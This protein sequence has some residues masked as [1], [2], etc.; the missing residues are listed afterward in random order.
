MNVEN[1]DIKRL[2]KLN[3]LR[4]IDKQKI[5]CESIKVVKKLIQYNPDEIFELHTNEEIY[6]IFKNT[7]PHHCKVYIYTNENLAK[8]KGFKFHQKVIAIAKK[9]SL[10]PLSELGPKIIIL[11]GLTSPENIGSIIRS[12]VGFGFNSLIYDHKTA[13][14]YLR[15]IIRVSM[16]NIFNIKIHKSDDLEKTMTVLKENYEILATCANTKESININHFN[17]SNNVGLIIGSEGHGIDK[18]IIKSSNHVIKIPID[19][20]VAHF[21]ASIAASICMYEIARQSILN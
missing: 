18:E 15:R 3:T 12:A 19:D 17:F 7:L 9:P 16:G 8:S 10:K 6:H 5:I 11:N 20:N 2:I 14:P 21:N 13:D 1:G 4:K